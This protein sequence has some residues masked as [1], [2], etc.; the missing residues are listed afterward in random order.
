MMI[1]R[2]YHLTML[3]SNLY[4]VVIALLHV[5]EEKTFLLIL[6]CSKCELAPLASLSKS[7]QR[8]PITLDYAYVWSTFISKEFTIEFKTSPTWKRP[9]SGWGRTRTGWGRT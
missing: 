6:S 4:V 3:L 2:F 1:V 9:Q 7:S 8:L 5:L